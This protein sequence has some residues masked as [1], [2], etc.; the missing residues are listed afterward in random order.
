M[1]KTMHN[2]L[3]KV[4]GGTEFEWNCKTMHIKCFCHKMALV[5]NAGLKELGLEAPPPP[6]IKKS[7][8]G[9]FPY[10]NTME[11]IDEEEEEEEGEKAGDKGVPNSDSENDIDSDDIDE[12]E[13]DMEEN[14]DTDIGEEK[15]TDPTPENKTKNGEKQE[16]FKRAEWID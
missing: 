12:N 5:V 6:K 7:F 2:K 4:G 10:S 9:S 16:F 11:R 15:E 8:L 14:K 1:A 3:I 13:D